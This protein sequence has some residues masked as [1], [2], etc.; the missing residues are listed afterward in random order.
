MSGS[1]AFVSQDPCEMVGLPAKPMEEPAVLYQYT[2]LLRRGTLS[3]VAPVTAAT[4]DTAPMEKQ[5]AVLVLRAATN[6]NGPGH[7]AIAAGVDAVA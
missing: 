7:A 2:P 3:A 6:K 1:S 5:E 4:L